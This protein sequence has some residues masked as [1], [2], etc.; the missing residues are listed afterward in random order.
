MADLLRQE[1]PYLHGHVDLHVEGFLDHAAAHPSSPDL[2][3]IVTGVCH[4]QIVVNPDALLH[5]GVI[6]GSLVLVS[7]AE[8]DRSKGTSSQCVAQVFAA[9]S[10]LPVP[11]C[12]SSSHGAGLSHAL[13]TPCKDGRT[14][15]GLHHA[16]YKTGVGKEG[17]RL[18]PLLAFNLGLSTWL[19]PFLSSETNGLAEQKVPASCLQGGD[20][21]GMQLAVVTTDRVTL[22]PLEDS[23]MTG[24]GPPGGHR[25]RGETFYPGCGIASLIRICKVGW[26][27]SRSRSA[28][29]FGHKEYFGKFL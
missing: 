2:R 13:V 18:S 21:S 4:H 1:A 14:L 10:P 7:A 11:P 26:V 23:F 28:E 16:G 22:K 9:V 15:A 27:G 20:A 12:S 3:S 5:V 25:Q 6:S 8:E 19:E 24:G 17:A 29:W